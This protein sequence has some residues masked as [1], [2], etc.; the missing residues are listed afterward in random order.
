MGFWFNDNKDVDSYKR[1]I[2]SIVLV[3]I[4]S[5]GCAVV[6]AVKAIPVLQEV[7]FNLISSNTILI[8]IIALRACIASMFFMLIIS[9]VVYGSSK[10]GL[11]LHSRR[12]LFGFILVIGAVI[13]N[14][15][16]S[17]L[18]MW[19][20]WLGHDASVG[21]VWGTP[22]AIRTD[23]YATGTPFAFAQEYEHYDY[24]NGLISGNPADMFMN[25]KYAPV[26]TPAEI[27]RPFHWGYLLLGSERGLAFYWAARLVVLFLAAYEFFL[28]VS[29][30]GKGEEHKGI[31]CLGAVLITFAPLTQ[32]W[33]AVNSLP[34]ML[35]AVFVS[36]VCFD[37]YLGGNRTMIRAIYVGV[38]LLCAGMFIL[39]LY[40]AWQIPLAYLLVLL[41]ICTVVR[42]WGNIRFSGKD[43][44]VLVAEIVVFCVILASAFVMSWDT[45]QTTLHT[46]YPGARQ[47]TGGGL[48]PLVLVS[49]VSSLFLPF[50]EWISV[51]GIE[52]SNA[53]EVSA[54]VDLFPVGIV[55][56]VI[57]MI[58]NKKVDVLNTCV[59]GLVAFFTLF[60]CVGFPLGL[61]K[62]LFLTPVTS[63]R[64]IVVFGVANIILLIRAASQNT[65]ETNM[66]VVI[67]VVLV[68]A[69]V[70]AA[71]NHF[72][73][74]L[75]MG[76]LLTA[77][78]AV[79]VAVLSFSFIAGNQRIVSNVAVPLSI[80][81]MVA[82]GMSV[83]PIQYGA[84][85][86]TQQPLTR[87]IQDLQQ[88]STGMWVADGDDS[89]RLANLLVANGIKTLNAL[90]VVPDLNT[91]KTLDTS[92]KWE[93]TYNR[94]A[95][96]A[97]QIQQSEATEPF[98][99]D[100]GDA[101]T[102]QVTPAQLHKLGVS[103]VLST[104]KLDEMQFDGYRFDRIGKTID[105][106][107]PYRLVE[108]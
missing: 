90:E 89:A 96:I 82:S 52:F 103:N 93:N 73:Y 81:G 76:R 80:L 47:S 62:I 36:I 88:N 21:V 97:V 53:T 102:L 37:R 65:R 7:F 8:T 61:S 5:V 22:R 54:F 30:N 38:I 87:Q 44:L 34:E 100:F 99:L 46:A 68:Y 72:T 104:Q 49:S 11:F 51:P 59:I 20:Y 39:S 33:F 16:G 24:F 19:N 32:W 41:I 26:W 27:F 28:T 74:P 56:A 83:N 55:L 92:G 64:T 86:L 35:I 6:F 78:C 101:F 75:Y 18:G 10:V 50:K 13:L 48:N 15:N 3:I 91:W 60:A 98:R 1:W 58:R 94:Y 95:Y 66:R 57:N 85:P 4:A 40:P 107:T 106:R 69:V 43:I 105:G 67:P 77:G 84:A 63:S 31:A 42:H 25:N 14:I 108:N 12:L 79:I 45:I 23:E 70:I 17:S 71:I 9:C 2:L 29:N